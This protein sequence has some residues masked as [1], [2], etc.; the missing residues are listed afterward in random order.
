LTEKAYLK[1]KDG[2]TK[3]KVGVVSFP[4]P[5]YA[6]YKFL[7]YVLKILEPISNKIVLIDGNT[8]RINITSKKVVI[9]DIDIGMHFLQN[10]KPTFYSAILWVLKCILVQ[11]KVSLE[12]IKVRKNVDVVIFYMAYPYYLFPV[13]IS[14]ILRKK[15]IEVVTRSKS[16]SSLL[17]VISLQDP[18][19]FRLLNGISP[20][21][22]VLIKELGLE[23]YKNKIL[24]E[25]A[26]FIDVTYYN[27][28]KKL[29]ERKDIV[30]FI[31]RVKR[32]KG[33]VEFVKTIPLVA[34]ENKNVDFLIGG[35]GDLLEWVKKE[36]RK[37]EDKYRVN[38]AIT[39][40][41]SENLPDYL[42]EL[43]LLV[44]P[45]Y[46]DA[47]PTIILEA[48]ACGTPVLATSVGGIPD[49]I[50]DEKTGFIMANNTPE[51]IA[52][53]I[54]RALNHQNLEEIAKNARKHIEEKYTYEAAVARYREILNK[55]IG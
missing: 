32:E 48:M 12:L 41:I 19:L 5:S 13:I 28:K 34:K 53:N 16:N 44:L 45:T 10:I 22:K 2:G 36:C 1:N 24:P 20:E 21:S 4:W 18:I 49:V 7:S 9:R 54:I 27:P 23:K 47:F 26:R 33:V 46:G 52:E 30:G 42:N 15:V 3:P 35:S 50:K 39:G 8:D 31:G 43:K 17:R 14:K 37:I 55:A 25:G 29:S 38:I 40:W 11:I 51:C 6:P